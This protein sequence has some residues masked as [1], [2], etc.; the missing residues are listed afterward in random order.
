[1]RSYGAAPKFLDDLDCATGADIPI[2]G[3]GER[4]VT[5]IGGS[6]LQ[7]AGCRFV[8]PVRRESGPT[9]VNCNLYR[10]RRGKGGLPARCS[11]SASKRAKKVKTEQ[12]AK[13]PGAS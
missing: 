5:H 6:A 8:S 12:R 10:E 1:V 7:S 13:A 2:G 4:E 3:A 9:L 11:P